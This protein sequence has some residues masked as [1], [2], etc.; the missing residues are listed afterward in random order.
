MSGQPERRARVKAYGGQEKQKGWAQRPWI[1]FLFPRV[2]FLSLFWCG[3]NLAFRYL[4]S[5]RRM[6]YQGRDA[7]GQQAPGTANGTL[8]EVALRGLVAASV[9][10]PKAQEVLESR[11][12]AR[13][14]GGG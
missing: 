5:N 10:G 11:A 4:S 8:L 7:E 14:P 3:G 12:K 9:Q 6:S 13:L 2:R 1:S